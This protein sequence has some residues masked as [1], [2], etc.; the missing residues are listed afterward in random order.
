MRTKLPPRRFSITTRVIFE[1]AGGA[2]QHLIV[3]F[4][5]D[6]DGRIREAFCASFHATSSILALANDACILLSRVLQY[7]E[8]IA[9]LAGSLGENR[10]EGASGGPPASIIGAIARA[11][12]QIQTEGV[13]K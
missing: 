1:A 5:F 9:A 2:E 11:G 4:G 13:S 6:D 3:T 8:D 7:G 10:P 12:A